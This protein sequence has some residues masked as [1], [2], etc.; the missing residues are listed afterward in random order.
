MPTSP[1]SSPQRI[2]TS[3]ALKVIDNFVKNDQMNVHFWPQFDSSLAELSDE[4][5][6][7]FEVLIFTTPWI[8]LIP[9]HT[10]IKRFL[11]DFLNSS[12]QTFEVIY[13]TAD[14]SYSVESCFSI[15]R[16]LYCANREARRERQ[17]R[18]RFGIKFATH[19]LDLVSFTKPMFLLS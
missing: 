10:V 16:T 3:L 4:L 15:D 5:R 19:D 9:R 11:S 17:R 12:F 1:P 7:I 6:Q 18:V 14:A 13:P 2:D 8:Q